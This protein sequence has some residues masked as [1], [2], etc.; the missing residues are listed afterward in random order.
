MNPTNHLSIF[1]VDIWTIDL[2]QISNRILKLYFL[3]V[4][5]IRVIFLAKGKMIPSLG[6]SK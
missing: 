2:W 6:K 4:F 3:N 1:L 5:L